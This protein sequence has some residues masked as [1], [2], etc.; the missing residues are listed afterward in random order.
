LEI[1][2]AHKALHDEGDEALGV[3]DVLVGLGKAVPEAKQ[4]RNEEFVP[5]K[6]VVKDIEDDAESVASLDSGLEATGEI[7]G[8]R[9][10]ELPV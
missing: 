10:V 3:E 2:Y 7:D 1:E 6:T 8:G 9:E 5:E 4:G